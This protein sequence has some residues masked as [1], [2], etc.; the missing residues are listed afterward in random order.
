MAESNREEIA[1]LEA[2][3]ANN[4]GGRVFTHLAEAY[5]KAGELERARSILET[6]IGRHPDYASA[7]VVLGRVLLDQGTQQDAAR[8]FRR[9][10]E[11]DPE[12]RVALRTMGDLARTERPAEAL[13]HYRQLQSLDPSDEELAELI[14][15]LDSQ[16]QR[17]VREAPTTPPEQPAEVLAGQEASEPVT[18]GTE[19]APSV[20]EV[21][22]EPVG[23]GEPP[24][25]A[26]GS[27]FTLDWSEA[28][29][30]L[31][32]ELP[33][34]IA[35]LAR[36]ASSAAEADTAEPELG[37]PAGQADAFAEPTA[38]VE[39]WR[40]RGEPVAEPSA[41]STPVE[42]AA[43]AEADPAADRMAFTEPVELP[44]PESIE[45]LSVPAVEGVFEPEFEPT[46]EELLSSNLGPSSP[47][48]DAAD[49]QSDLP[50]ETLAE[51]Y[52]TQGFYRRSAEVYRALLEQRPNDLRLRQ[53][54]QEVEELDR[55]AQIEPVSGLSLD[56]E[57]GL[58][59]ED[60][61]EPALPLEP[62]S[63]EPEPI[64]PAGEA[65][66]EG[67][68]SA[69]IGGA[70]AADLAGSPYAWELDQEED[71]AGPSLH[72]YLSGVL[73][74][75]PTAM[76]PVTP[77]PAE[78]KDVWEPVAE[79]PQAEEPQPD[80][81]TWVAPETAQ[82]LEDK[83]AS[84]SEEPQ[85][86]EMPVAATPEVKEEVEP[87]LQS[88]TEHAVPQPLE[89]TPPVYQAVGPIDAQESSGNVVQDAFDEW[90]TGVPGEQEQPRPT[91]S[92]EPQ[93]GD[94]DAGVTEGSE[95]ADEESDDDLEMFRSWLQSL[96]R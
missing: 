11:L 45:D 88:S 53:R 36:H 22:R 87:W 10:L 75:H 27:D 42:S 25:Q 47:L 93:T 89:P 67:V 78:F 37:T 1:K 2:I 92:A 54:L 59:I 73:A 96:K 29:T 24:A 74:W 32:A 50:T 43:A 64:Q 65:W 6:G 70:G 41:W 72:E 38:E 80:L 84:S 15:R 69:W 31:D 12:N 17:A 20:T 85:P 52:R 21:Q 81:A 61:Q 33:G 5:R 56:L 95:S 57:P 90:F 66:V 48:T 63:S 49:A 9:V 19:E 34:D 94:V 55:P 3:Y 82:V 16:I 79:E 13:T 46:F 40:D 30:P 91:A 4:P 14:E 51:L 8:S 18:T 60:S 68:E 44:V 62:A 39:P 23:Q 76:P 77:P 28:E 35:E 26:V 58:L 83:T 86:W 7:H 71:T